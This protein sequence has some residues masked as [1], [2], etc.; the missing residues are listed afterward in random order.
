[1]VERQSKK[2]PGLS[3]KVKIAAG[4]AVVTALVFWNKSVFMEKVAD[5]F[6]NIKQLPSS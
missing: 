5:C 4:M 3:K 1:M 6:N 2:Q